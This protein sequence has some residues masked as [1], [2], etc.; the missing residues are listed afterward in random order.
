DRNEVRWCDVQQVRPGGEVVADLVAQQNREQRER[1]GQSLRPGARERGERDVPAAEEVDGVG[2]G[3]RPRQDGA[4]ERGGE[5][6]GEK[7]HSVERP[8]LSPRPSQRAGEDEMTAVGLV[9]PVVVT[10]PAL[11][12][13]SERGGGGG[14]GRMYKRINHFP[15]P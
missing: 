2:V 1:K 5:Q 11:E 8:P 6:G 12:R 9:G 15:I 3:N 4:C 10:G 7:Q 13:Q 14:V